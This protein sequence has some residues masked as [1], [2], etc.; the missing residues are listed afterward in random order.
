MKKLLLLAA[1]AMMVAACSTSHLT[2]EEKAMQQARTTQMVGRMI[3]DR[4]FTVDVNYMQPMG[5][6]SRPL[7]S[8]YRVTIS[9]DTLISV[10]PYAGR[11]YNVPYGGGSG[12]HFTSKITAFNATHSAK[13]YYEVNVATQKE[14]DDLTYTLQIFDNGRSHISVISR[15]RDQITFNGDMYFPN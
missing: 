4:H 15:Q 8:G 13:G 2:S 10:L 5:A 9:G 12:L 6:P 7:S 11:G 14:G 3:A 1:A